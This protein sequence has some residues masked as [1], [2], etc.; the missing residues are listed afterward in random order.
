M[1]LRRFIKT[2]YLFPFMLLMGIEGDGGAAPVERPDNISADEWEGL[3]NEER[4]GLLMT[5]EG[6]DGHVAEGEGEGEELTDEELAAIAEGG[7]KPEGE[8]ESEGEVTD[9]EEEPIAGETTGEEISG[10]EQAVSDSDLLAFRPVVTAAEIN[11]KIP[12]VDVPDDIQTKIDALDDKFENGFEE[13]GEQKT[14]SLRE[15]NKQRDALTREA[16]DAIFDAKTT[17]RE[18]ARETLVWEKEQ[19][20]FMQAHPE[21]VEKSLRGSAVFGALGEAI[22]AINADPKSV[23]KTGIQILIEA[24]KQVRDAGLLPAKGTAKPAEKKVEAK[25]VVKK[26]DEALPK[27]KTLA[28]V[29]ASA[30]EN[31]SGDPFSALDN[32]TGEALE[33]AID[34][35]TPAQREVWDNR[36]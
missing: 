9:G 13:D 34:R 32:L 5:G 31:V 25:P 4:E 21:Y 35:L 8:E 30:Q 33:R 23:N 17:A 22:N 1:K 18:E 16:Q 11:A 3:S 14:L 19:A 29:P 24:D 7:E 10:E 26:P 36:F 6:E 28:D 2:V 27:H 20:A 15:Y 12:K